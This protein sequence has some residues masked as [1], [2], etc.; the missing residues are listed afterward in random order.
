VVELW[1]ADAV[2]DDDMS[3]LIERLRSALERD[4]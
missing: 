4:A 1:D 2:E 3:A